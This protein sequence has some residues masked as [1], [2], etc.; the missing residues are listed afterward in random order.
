MDY[1]KACNFVGLTMVVLNPGRIGMY[2]PILVYWTGTYGGLTL[3]TSININ[4]WK[5][6]GKPAR[7]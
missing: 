1:Y 4:I 2:H 3:D 5:T 7:N 6:I